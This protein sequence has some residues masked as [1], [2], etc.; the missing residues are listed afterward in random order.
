MKQLRMIKYE[1]LYLIK[2]SS[3]V[4]MTTL[5]VF[6]EDSG[7]SIDFWKK[8]AL[9]DSLFASGNINHLEKENNIVFLYMRPGK[10]NKNLSFSIPVF[11]ELLNRWEE[12]Y[13]QQV[14][15][16]IIT[17]DEQGNATIEGKD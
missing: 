1:N 3:N 7:G 9:S 16:I 15:E 8:W 11:I 6:L 2:E 10:R 13:K 4:Y 12:L 17:L 5:G 14:N